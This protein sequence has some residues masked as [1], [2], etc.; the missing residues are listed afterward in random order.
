M[1]VCGDLNDSRINQGRRE[2]IDHNLA[3]HA[4]IGT[5]QDAGTVPLDIPSIGTHPQTTPRTS[6]PS[7]HRPVVAHFDL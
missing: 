3:S 6:P 2:L 5:L 4:L 1:L 7:D